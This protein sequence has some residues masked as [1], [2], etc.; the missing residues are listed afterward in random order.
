MH[1]CLSQNSLVLADTYTDEE[2]VEENLGSNLF[3]TV[4]VVGTWGK[5]Q[6]SH[7]QPPAR[8]KENGSALMKEQHPPEDRR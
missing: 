2:Q 7:S 4:S 3:M 8:C 1:P 6:G 5:V